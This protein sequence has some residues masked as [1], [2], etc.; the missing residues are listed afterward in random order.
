MRKWFEKRLKAILWIV[1]ITFFVSIFYMFGGNIFEEDGKRESKNPAGVIAKVNKEEILQ[2]E[3]DDAYRNLLRFYSM[4]FP[5]QIRP[6]NLIDMKALVLDQLVEREIK[7]QEAKKEKIKVSKKEIEKKISEIA[8]NFKSRKEF[9]ERI[10]QMGQNMQMLRDSI[11]NDLLIEKLEKKIKKSAKV[12]D[13]E[14]KNKYEQVKARHILIKVKEDKDKEKAEKEAKEKAQ[15]IIDEYNNG[16]DFSLLAKK[17]SEDEGSKEV[18]GDLGFFGRGQMVAEFE[19]VAFSLKPGQISQP[20]KTQYGYH[21]IKVEDK[22]E[23]KGPDFEKEKKRLKKELG[24]S[25]EFEVWNKW[26]DSVKK[27]AKVEI[28]DKEIKGYK[29]DQEGKTDEA[30][31]LYEELI[32]D[33]PY[34]SY[35]YYHLGKFYEKKDKH[36]DAIK[37]YKLAIKYNEEDPNFYFALG[38]ILEKKNDK[39]NAIRNFKKASS[40]AEDDLSLRY[41]LQEAFKNLGE[42]DA[43][44]KEG[45]QIAKI[46]DEIRRKQEEERI[47]EEEAKIVKKKL[48]KPLE[49]KVGG[50]EK[51]I[52]PIKVEVGEEETR[53]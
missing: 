12:T 41:Q 34:D 42:K 47:K 27:R 45:Q 25:K 35:I 22:K 6:I 38:K 28:I 53:R 40:L 29:K 24:Q 50:K 48:E 43:E 10:Y 52:Q 18:G 16:V 21:I 15:K 8:K 17:Y 9:E 33:N 2:Q 13:E 14:I 32:K 49:V 30:I 11:K 39:K 44:E 20:V 4:N 37:N 36:D 46:Q 1:V 31:K 3:F 26:L 51:E 23:A 19:R 7:L 5:Q